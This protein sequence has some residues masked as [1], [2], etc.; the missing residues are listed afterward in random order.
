MRRYRRGDLFLKRRKLM[1]DWARHCA[2]VTTAEVVQLPSRNPNSH[3]AGETSNPRW[4]PKK[5]R[6]THFVHPIL[7]CEVA[8]E[9]WTATGKIRQASFKGLRE[10]KDPKDVVVE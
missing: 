9:T 5:T 2:R 1:E 7:V 8:F 10:D 6:T 3:G 4:V